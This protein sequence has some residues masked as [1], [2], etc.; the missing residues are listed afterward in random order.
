MNYY[1]KGFKSLKNAE[2]KKRPLQTKQKKRR[3][4]DLK[5]DLLNDEALMIHTRRSIT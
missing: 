4:G 1:Y 3:E 2:K 5:S